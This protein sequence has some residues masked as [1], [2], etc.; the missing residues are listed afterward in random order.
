MQSRINDIRRADAEIVAVCVDPVEK[1]AEFVRDLGLAFPVLSDEKL[2]VIDTYDIRHEQGNT[3]AEQDIARPAV[4][5][6]DRE[7][8]VRWRELT[9]NYRVRVRPETILEQLAAIP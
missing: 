1:N 7:G 5:V 3:F 6:L 2:S 4:F 8:V 9:D